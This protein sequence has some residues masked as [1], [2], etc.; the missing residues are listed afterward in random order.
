MQELEQFYGN[1]KKLFD[2]AL[3][4]KIHKKYRRKSISKKSGG[5]R[6]LLIPPTST[7]KAQ[8]LLNPILQALYIPPKPV[9]AFI[10]S[11]ENNV[12]NI[13]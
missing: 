6:N 2:L 7:D 8:K 13:F 10:K 9:H 1:Y 3:Y 4:D 12:K 5:K 11:D